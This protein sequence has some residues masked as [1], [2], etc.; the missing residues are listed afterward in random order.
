MVSIG[1]GVWVQNSFIFIFQVTDTHA[2][3]SATK[4]N[5]LDAGRYTLNLKNP[6]GS[7]SVSVKVNVLGKSI[8]NS[9]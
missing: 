3:L 9:F 6:S 2:I 4:S 1:S 7:D 8:T 5:R